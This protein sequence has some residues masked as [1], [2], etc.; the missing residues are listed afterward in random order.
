MKLAQSIIAASGLLL[1]GNMAFAG[2]DPPCKKGEQCRYEAAGGK[3]YCE[4]LKSV[5]DTGSISGGSATKLPGGSTTGA[6]RTQ[7]PSK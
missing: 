1:V 4:K 3:Y 5:R 6:A 2:C 7:V